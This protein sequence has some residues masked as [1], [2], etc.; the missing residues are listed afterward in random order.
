MSANR[1][2]GF[3][4]SNK[5][6][7]RFEALEAR[8]C[9]SASLPKILPALRPSATTTPPFASITTNKQGNT[10]TIKDTEMGDTIA[11]TDD[12]GSVSVLITYSSGGTLTGSGG[13]GITNVVINASGGGDTVDYNLGGTLTVAAAVKPAFRS[14]PSSTNHESISI[15][16]SGGGNTVNFADANGLTGSNLDLDI[17]ATGGKNTVNIGAGGMAASSTAFGDLTNSNLW[18]NVFTGGGGNTVNEDF[19]AMSGS[20]L[21]STFDGTGGGDTLD[22]SLTTLTDPLLTGSQAYFTAFGG[23]GANNL[24]LTVSGEIAAD[25]LL[26][27]QLGGGWKGGDTIDFSYT[28]LLDGKLFVGTTGAGGNE[29]ISQS[30]TANEGSTG[31]LHSL[32]AAGKGSEAN[33]L[34]LTLTD[35]SNGGSDTAASTL[36]SVNAV[37]LDQP[38]DTPTLAVS[39]ND[40]TDVT[41]ITQKGHGWFWGWLGFGWGW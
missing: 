25:S 24:G 7:A 29:T 11:V 23:G 33:T 14:S 2:N 4:L 18:L 30:I 6:H 36:K 20:K 31:S 5:H 21:F 26:S 17:D 16:V 39:A 8:R 41:V 9:L 27:A 22:A 38:L 19:G 40:T 3:R 15:N 34:A 28:G 35:D 32:I 37:I 12:A 13:P 10:L 1:R